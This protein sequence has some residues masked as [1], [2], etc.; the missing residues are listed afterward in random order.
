MNVA[1][2]LARIGELLNRYKLEVIMVGNAAAAI[3]GAP[4]TTVDI[5]FF[6]RK[7]P[8]NIKKLK[9]INEELGAVILRPFYPAGDWFRIMRDDDTLQIDFMPTVAGFPSFEGMR[10]RATRIDF[11]GHQLL[12]AS[13]ADIIKSKRAA[14]RPK[15]RA[16]LHV[17]ENALA[18]TK[19]HPQTDAGSHEEGE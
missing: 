2:I 17:L 13:L 15:D 16:V 5:D 9:S 10:K 11:N 14:G 3:Q 4:V 7:T 18:Q 12:V 1:P 19:A 8:G 6:F